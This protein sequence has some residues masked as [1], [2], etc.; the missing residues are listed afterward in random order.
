MG[1]VV[2]IC[3]GK[4]EEQ[5]REQWYPSQK[6]TMLIR[7]GLRKSGQDLKRWVTW[8]FDISDSLVYFIGSQVNLPYKGENGEVAYIILKKI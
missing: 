5:R 3:S 7:E 6:G 8:N 2:K 4:Q 1:Q